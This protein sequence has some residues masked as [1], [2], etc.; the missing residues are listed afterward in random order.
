[1]KYDI[2][3]DV[4]GCFD[5][6]IQLLNKLGYSNEKDGIFRH[7][8]GRTLIFVGD[9]TDKGPDSQ[10]CLDLVLNQVMHGPDKMIMG[11]HDD[12]IYRYFKGNPVTVKKSMEWVESDYVSEEDA[13]RYETFL[14]QV[15]RTFEDIDG[16]NKLLVTHA[17]PPP[18]YYPLNDAHEDITL[19]GPSDESRTNVDGYP[20]R[21]DWVK[22]Y[23]ETDIKRKPFVVYGH[24]MYEEPRITDHTCCIDTGACVG[25]KLSAF[26][27]PEKEVVSVNSNVESSEGVTYKKGESPPT[28][29]EIGKTQSVD[30]LDTMRL[31]VLLEKFNNN[32]KDYL[33]KIHRDS[34]L[35]KRQ[36]NGLTIAN[37]SASLYMPEKEHQL[38]AKGIVYDKNTWELVSLPLVKMYNL[39]NNDLSDKTI[40]EIVNE[41]GYEVNYSFKEDG[42]M[43]QMFQHEGEIYVTTRGVMGM[44]GSNDH[45]KSDQSGGFDFIKTAKELA[46][47][48]LNSILDAEHMKG[49]SYVFELI[50]PQNRIVTDYSKRGKEK[51]LSLLS[52]YD[53]DRQSYWSEREI[54]DYAETSNYDIPCPDWLHSADARNGGWSQIKN[55]TQELSDKLEHDKSIPEGMVMSFEKN[56][57]IIHRVKVK[58]EQ[59]REAFKISYNVGYKNVLKHLT[60]RPSL[61]NDWEAYLSFLKQNDYVEEEIENKYEPHYDKFCEYVNHIK[62]VKEKLDNIMKEAY[63]KIG[64]ETPTNDED[65]GEYHKKMA[66]YL[67]NHD[68]LE[69]NHFTTCM[70]HHRH[71]EECRGD[72]PYE[73][74]MYAEPATSS[75]KGIIQEDEKCEKI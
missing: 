54:R 29:R 43:I 31:D 56:E 46:R 65:V 28:R 6:L 41:G 64:Y 51:K 47:S 10:M 59:Y 69:H 27:F 34:D 38:F 33:Q 57:E 49:K 74:I 32:T 1:M 9:I 39:N 18:T 50:H 44:F 55:K 12:K 58:T 21:F 45:F 61:W 8:E 14:S 53:H 73:R 63:D 2:I 72:I 13:Q 62:D 22:P 25:N 5:E 15:P 52:I 20:L 70:N 30:G 11:N 16:D 68:G 23:E 71:D 42:T 60:G 7:E 36:Y 75:H 4:H 17:A 3:G 26:R 48:Q 24:Y 66:L 19:Y 67:K 37:A 40:Q 35:I